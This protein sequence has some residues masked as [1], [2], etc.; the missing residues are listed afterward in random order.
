MACKGTFSQVPGMTHEH[1]GEVMIQPTQAVNETFY[2]HVW[3]GKYY[4]NRQKRIPT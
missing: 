2:F 3:Y 1:L 4:G